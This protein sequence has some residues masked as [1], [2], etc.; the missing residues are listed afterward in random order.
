MLTASSAVLRPS[1][2]T[3]QYGLVLLLCNATL[4]R[5]QCRNCSGRCVLRESANQGA[6]CTSSKNPL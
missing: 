4:S 6:E 5:N 3:Y 1:L 2:T